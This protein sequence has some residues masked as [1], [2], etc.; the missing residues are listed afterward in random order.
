[1]FR[2]NSLSAKKLYLL[3]N[4]DSGHYNVI[5]NIKAAMAKRYICN[6]CDT[7]YDF[8]HKCDK[9]ILYQ[10][11]EKRLWQCNRWFL[12]EKCFQNHLI[13]KVKGKLVCQWRQ[14]CRNCSF[15]VTFGS[16]HECFKKFCNL[17]NKTQPS[18]HFCYAATLKPSKLS[19][20]FFVRFLR[21]GV[22]T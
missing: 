14:V 9:A 7:L 3:Y 11:S 1:M 5:T 21:Y 4:S 17:C 12:S 15:T 13:L 16:E 20:K 19:N 18:G 2:G 22:Y 6:A 8:S 10:R